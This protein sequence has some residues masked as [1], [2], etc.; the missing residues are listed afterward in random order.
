MAPGLVS[1]GVELE[2]SIFPA[3]FVAVNAGLTYAKTEYQN[4]LVGL[5]G[6]PFAP[7]S[8]QLP[9]SQLS[10]APKYVV[11]GSV[12]YSPNLGSNGLSGLAY[13]DFRYQSDVNTGS[14][15][16]PE[17]QQDGYIVFNGRVGLYTK[18]KR[19]GIE[20]F[21]QN[22]LNN[23]YQQIAADAPIQGGGTIGGVRRGSATAN[24]LFIAFPGEPRTYGIT[25]KGKF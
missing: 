1:K 2:A 14:D 22:L 18:D 9:Q 23:R 3:R 19:I 24:Q 6:R 20:L 4:N 21:G 25:L 16:D 7:T 12:G 13:L 17:K 5:G 11:T 8:F 15:L 10:N